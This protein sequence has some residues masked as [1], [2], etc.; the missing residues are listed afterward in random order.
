MFD[1]PTH[2]IGEDVPR[3]LHQTFP[4]MNVPEN[5]GR[6]IAAL[7]A[8]NPDW[9]YTL[10]DNEAVENYIAAAYGQEVLALYH[11]INPGYGAARADLFRYLLMYREGG[12]YL[13]IKSG[14]DRPLNEIVSNSAGFLLTQWTRGLGRETFGV[15]P[16]LAHCPGGEYQQWQITTVRGHPFLRAVI[17]HVLNNIA[18]Y[19]PW[20]NGTGGNGTYRVTGPIAYTLAIQPLLSLYDHRIATDA[21]AGLIYNATAS[22]HKPSF[23]GHYLKRTDAIVSPRNLTSRLSAGAYTALQITRRVLRD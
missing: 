15:H 14:A 2:S 18:H 22:S 20:R 10:Y 17:E 6:Q 7:R 16:E 23:S 12:I 19:S 13:D 1:L 4:T 3:H 8:R 9:N 21:E 11:K 5:F